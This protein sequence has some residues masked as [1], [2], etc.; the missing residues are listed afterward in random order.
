MK[1]GSLALR[2]GAGVP[3]A[4]TLSSTSIRRWFW[5][6]N[7]QHGPVLWN[8]GPCA[9][10]DNEPFAFFRVLKVEK[11]YNMMDKLVQVV[12]HEVDLIWHVDDYAVGKAL[13]KQGFTELACGNETQLYAFRV[14]REAWIEEQAGQ[15][16][17][18]CLPPE[19]PTRWAWAGNYRDVLPAE[20]RDD[21]VGV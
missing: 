20:L 21:Y 3:P 18:S 8:T 16:E 9:A 13:W 19:D 17:V 5:H 2:I 15:Q 11:E 10:D 14:A 4:I 1:T 6:R 7:K 12:M